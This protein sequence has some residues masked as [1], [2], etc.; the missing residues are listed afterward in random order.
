[1]NYQWE[2]KPVKKTFENIDI[3]VETV[4]NT[5]RRKVNIEKIPPTKTVLQFPS[6]NNASYHRRFDFSCLYG[7]DCDEVVFAIQRTI[8]QLTHESIHSNKLSLA[9]ISHYC[10]SGSK[11]FISFCQLMS[12]NLE[13]NLLLADLN[14]D[15]IIRYISYLS[16][17]KLSIGGQKSIYTATKST[18]VAMEKQGWLD[19][20]Q[21]HIF[22]R[23]PYPKSNLLCKG[24]KPLSQLEM[25]KVSRALAK[26][27]LRIK[28]SPGAL[29]SYDCII[30]ILAIS[31]RT[32][33]NPTPLLEL[34]VDC[35]QPHPLKPDR[36]LLVSFKRRGNATHI[37]S[38]RKSEEVS[39]FSTVMLD[40]AAIIDLVLER[41]KAVR[42]A[43]KSSRLWA[44]T[45]VYNK[46][47]DTIIQTSALPSLINAFT[48]R[49]ELSDDDGKTL[50]LNLSRL[51][52]T[53]I[54]RIWELSG[55]DPIVTAAMGNHSITVS[56]NHYL[57]A[58]PEAEKNF[59]LLGEIRVNELLGKNTKTPAENTPIA[60]CKDSLYGHR[61]PK[62]GQHCTEFLDCFRCKSFVVTEGDLYRVFSLYWLL[63][64]ERNL[65]GAKR[66]NRFYA[67]IT[68]IIDDDITPQFDATTVAIAKANAKKNPHPY[69][70]KTEALEGLA[71]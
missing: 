7:K 55:Q 66:W 50:K 69:W 16:E 8:E 14:Q 31:M 45:S 10:H 54:N 36:R 60:K 33:I 24:Q 28:E 37:T 38:L 17:T 56:N 43:M 67:H 22:P 32:G 26:E 9:T 20:S 6:N 18:L 23:N 12:V 34:P 41:N 63:V 53:F 11:H 48:E 68:R 57:E 4:S 2:E 13:R 27:L 42:D 44:C 61:A 46:R 62:N 30:C 35:L 15:L 71:V 51:R 47:A 70:K 19:K 49:N 29:N 52:K 65:I 3:K 59:S 64:I 39:L 40:I 5:G 25:R 21:R 58:P 1:M